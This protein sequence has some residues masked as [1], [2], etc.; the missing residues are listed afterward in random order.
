MAFGRGKSRSDLGEHRIFGDEEA[1]QLHAD[2]D[3][4]K[5]QLA[6]L[7]EQVRAQFTSI[8][9]HAE[10]AQEQ[11]SV[12]RAEAR[13]D[14]ERSRDMLIGLIEQARSDASAGVHVPGAPPGP[15]VAALNERVGLLEEAVARLSDDLARAHSR[16]ER[17]AATMDAFI[18]TLLAEQR[19]ESPVGL[20][21]A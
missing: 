3:E 1:A 14:M 16:A 21:V 17:M 5:A 12:A 13:A 2:V 10:I 9:A 20:A 4:L 19:G 15:S 6:A 11:V 8:A 18:D 7:N